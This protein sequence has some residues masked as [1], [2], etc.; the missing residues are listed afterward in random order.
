MK[1]M[2]D[3]RLQVLRPCGRSDASLVRVSCARMGH[4]ENVV[5]CN[6]CMHAIT[7]C[8]QC[9]EQDHMLVRATRLALK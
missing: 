4:V 3:S 8:E 1:V 7:Y 9:M 2:T 6:K 5:M